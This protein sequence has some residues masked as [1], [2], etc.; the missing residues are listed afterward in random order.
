MRHHPTQILRLLD[1]D[2]EHQ[3]IF[4]CY[5]IILHYVCICGSKHTLP[6][7]IKIIIF[8]YVQYVSYRINSSIE[9][10]IRPSNAIFHP[11]TL[12]NA[13]NKLGF[14][15][16]CLWLS[17][18]RSQASLSHWP[19]VLDLWELR[20]RYMSELSSSRLRPLKNTGST[21]LK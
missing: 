21:Q 2:A 12:S 7:A 18:W 14:L 5:V 4:V 15:P 1:T 20:A 8:L 11:N 3:R 13:R 9:K 6:P 16:L 10:S 19:S 17:N